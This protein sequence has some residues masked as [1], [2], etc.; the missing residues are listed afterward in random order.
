MMNFKKALVLLLAA[1]MLLGTAVSC[2]KDT[3]E[4]ET[5]PSVNETTPAVT[6]TEEPGETEF[7]RRSV[8]DNLPEI[9]FGGR[10]FRFL[11]R[12]GYEWQIVADEDAEGLDREIYERNQRVEARFDTKVDVVLTEQEAQDAL[13]QY[14]MS[15]ENVAEI[16]DHEQYMALTPVVYDCFL[17]WHEIPYINWDQPWWNRD[18][19]DTQTINGYMYTVSGDLALTAMQQTFCLAFNADL[20]EEWGYPTDTLYDL[21]WNGEWTY[22]KMIEMTSNFYKD[23]NG[24][25]IANS[26]DIFGYG[27][28]FMRTIPW[29]TT[30]GEH[31]LT[32]TPDGQSL[33]V[34]LA[35]E[36]M[37]SFL[38]KMINYHH[39]TV[40]VNK[41]AQLADFTNGTIGLYVTMFEN[42]FSAFTELPFTYGLL[43]FPK[44]DT[45]QEAYY[46]APNVNFS[47]YGMP[48]TL[49]TEDYEMVGVMMEALNAESWKTVYPAY[50]DEALKGR[51][52]SDENMSKMVD[53]ITE[54]RVYEIAV[55]FGQFLGGFK[56]PYMAANYI[57]DGNLKM[58][59]DLAEQ[60]GY[61][62]ETLGG[63]LVYFGVEGEAWS[64]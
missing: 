22:D 43:P 30:I 17:N 53:L 21:V 48:I 57:N 29:A 28:T 40:G 3:A 18:A 51:Y 23:E 61:F 41:D 62:D 19:I 15:N 4:D 52:S 14:V 38:E 7:D 59:S 60:Q 20:M 26:G 8:S 45:A 5:T 31:P 2:T 50:Y 39:S 49:P 54:S 63:V 16:C 10:D 24:D 34:T 36:K 33:K 37:Y 35:S 44:Y 12:N 6:E 64:G 58:A 13:V 27:V 47:I 32:L 11:I 42:C 25:S 46:T 1:Q 56:L 55:Q 9:T